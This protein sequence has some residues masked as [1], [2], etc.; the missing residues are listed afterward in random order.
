MSRT[1][2]LRREIAQILKKEAD[3]QSDIAKHTAEANKH[4]A[5]AAKKS[6]AAFKS[7]S[8]SLRS[9]YLRQAD[10]FL[11]KAAA[12]EKKISDARKKLATLASQ[13]S[14]KQKSLL[15]SEKSDRDKISREAAKERREEMNH[16]RQ[17]TSMR[18]RALTIQPP[19]PEP[20]RVLYLTTN[21]EAF[22]EGALRT[23]AEVRNVQNELKGTLYRDRIQIS[24]LPAATYEDMLRG[25]NDIR[26]HVVHF[27]GHG[28]NAGIL[29]D[30]GSIDNPTGVAMNF[31]KL[32]RF[33]SATDNPPRLLVLN[34]CDTLNGAEIL[35]DSVPIVVAMSDSITDIAAATFATKFYS[36]IASAQSVGSALNQGKAILSMLASAEDHLPQSVSRDDVDIDSLILVTPV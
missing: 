13:K 12:S 6:E 2:T 4:A 32:A 26:P 22:G 18:R 34:A 11:K 10:S 35:L 31:D 20:L 28:G 16:V 30:N 5:D 23:D 27:S 24:H 21:P 1:E 14:S 15:A 3:T 36:A 9:S 25:L 33:L 17:V 7:K 29:F 19:K 8:V